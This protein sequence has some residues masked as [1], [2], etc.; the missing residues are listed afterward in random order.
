MLARNPSHR[1]KLEQ[2]LVVMFNGPVVQRSTVLLFV[3]FDRFEL[4]VV[5]QKVSG[6]YLQH[7]NLLMTVVVWQKVN[8]SAGIL[9]S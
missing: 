8:N 6:V 5:T 2:L 7:T 3:R 4:N 9:S 1:N